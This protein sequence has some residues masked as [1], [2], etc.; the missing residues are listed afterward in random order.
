MANAASPEQ[1]RR[2][3]RKAALRRGINPDLFEG[4][5]G[6]E[7]NFDANAGSSAG[8]QGPAQ[9]MPETARGMGV[10]L[11][12]GRVSDDLDGAARLMA[13]YLHQYG[14]S[15]K[16]AL[17]AYNAGPGRVGK[18]LYAETAAYINKILN[19][20][21]D[22][23]SNPTGAQESGPS[24]SSGTPT[25]VE[26]NDPNLARQQFFAQWLQ[27]KKPHSPLLKLGVVDPNMSTLTTSPVPARISST[28]GPR[29]SGTGPNRA[30]S[31]AARRIGVS[32]EGGNNRGP[33]IDAWQKRYGMLGQPWCGIFVGLALEKAGVRGLGARVASVAAIEEDARAG[34]AG[35][36]AFVS[37]KQARPGDALI[38]RKGGHVGLVERVD[39]DGT[40]HTIEGNTGNGSVQRRAH[41]P[42]QVYGAARPRYSH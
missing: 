6:A 36:R 24:A 22:A 17:T 39:E 35:F 4:Q 32:E 10:D 23:H 5:I 33:R 1:V 2:E 42:D 27:R 30:V 25:T 28:D 11:N 9:F 21:T 3:A 19:G 34:R 37:A 41:R 14:G 26:R 18:P 20:R 8:A 13:K 40:I 12:D 29:I 15:Y 31:E 16:K 7:S 38:T